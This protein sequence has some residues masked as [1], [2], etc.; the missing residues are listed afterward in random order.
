MLLL[1]LTASLALALTADDVGREF[2]GDLSDELTAAAT[3]EQV[4]ESLLAAVSWTVSRMRPD[5]MSQYGGYGP[6]DLREGS[7]D[8]SLEHA[9]RLLDVSPDR[10]I[11]DPGMNLRGGAAILAE[12]A[13][14][15][16]GGVLP[17]VDDLEAWAPAVR[18]F[19]GA[20][21]PQVQ[22][23]FEASVLHTVR[24]GVDAE[25]DG[26]AVHIAPIPVDVKGL[27]GLDVPSSG[28]RGRAS[29]DYSGAAQFVAASSSNYS[30]YSRTGSDIDY[31][32]I[33]TVQGSYNGCIS[34]FQNSS[35]SVSAHYVVQSSDGEVTQMV[36]EEDVA[37]HA[38]N[39]SYNEASIGIEHEGYVDAPDTWYTD[40]M[41]AGSAALSADI[42]SRTD[43]E[44]DRDH[45][46][47][48]YEVPSATHT[49]PG[50]GWDWDYYMELV[51][52]GE[53]TVLGTVTGVVA[54]D[55][56]YSGERVVGASVWTDAGGSTS[57]DASGY[58]TFDDVPEGEVVL[59]A[60]ADGYGT[61]SCT[62]EVTSSSTFWCSMALTASDTEESDSDDPVSETE[63]DTEPQATDTD[64][65][66]QSLVPGDRVRLT[67]L[68][69]CTTT[70]AAGGLAGALL[71]FA[72][73]A[74]RRFS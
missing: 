51:T 27:T 18:A 35:A 59:Y 25:V 33:H 10:L 19:S 8:P 44:P 71:A 43:V 13:R 40:A 20:Y 69:G 74:R 62:T 63:S 32:I 55:D 57:T 3:A 46:I 28:P 1:S 53:V 41:Y 50:S 52:G 72:A 29:T 66:T 5:A 2:D 39:W 68:G 34:W 11:V 22:A 14:R 37:W 15:A 7:V 67:E 65:Q 21:D 54:I 58:F 56:I 30:D 4:P 12:H 38:G 16:N 9:A 61:A 48:H 47:A 73:A 31:I 64:P 24:V 42:V 70:P 26:M 6:M 49:D 45:I 36:K 17:P 60:N 23:M